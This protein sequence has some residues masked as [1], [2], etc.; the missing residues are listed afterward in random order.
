MNQSRRSISPVVA[1]ALLMT[2]AVLSVVLVQS[3]TPVGHDF[4]TIEDNPEDTM[5]PGNDTYERP[6]EFACEEGCFAMETIKKWRSDMERNA[7]H[8]RSCQE[9]CEVIYG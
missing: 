5:N 7:S 6:N 3:M 8:Y 9:Y 4:G 1:T 2:L